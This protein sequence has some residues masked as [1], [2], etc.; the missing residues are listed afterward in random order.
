MKQAIAVI[1][2]DCCFPG[3]S[4]PRQYWR[5]LLEGRVHN[6]VS[7]SGVDSS[8]EHERCKHG[9][10]T[11]DDADL[12]NPE[13][14]GISSNEAALMDPQQ[15]LILMSAWRA[16]EDS[17]HSPR[18]M[19]GTRTGVYVGLMS[20]EWT[21]W[22]TCHPEFVSTLSGS[23]SGFCMVANRVSYCLNFTGP[24]LAIDTACSSSLTA[25]HYAYRDLQAGECDYALVGGVNLLLGEGLGAFYHAAGL[26]SAKGMCRPFSSEA[27]GISRSEGVATVFLRRF[28]DALA[29]NDPIYC[30]ILGSAV[31]HNGRSNG[32]TAPNR[33]AQVRVM[34]DAYKMAGIDPGDVAFLEAHG[35]GTRL[36]DLIELNALSD[37]HNEKTRSHSLP[38]SS[39]KGN[40]GHAEGAAGIAGFIKAALTVS[41][42]VLPP[43]PCAEDEIFS[44]GATKSFLEIPKYPK[45]FS[46][47]K[48]IGSVSSFGL[49]GSN[50]H[51]VVAGYN[52]FG[53]KS[54]RPIPRTEIYVISAP[55]EAG[56]RETIAKE[57]SLL[58]RSSS[59]T[60]DLGWTSQCTDAGWQ[61]RC[62][63]AGKTNREIAGK[64]TDRANDPGSIKVGNLQSSNI[65]FMLPGQGDEYE[66][67]AAQLCDEWPIFAEHH[68]M[69]LQALDKASQGMELTDPDSTWP[70]QSSLFALEY[71][72]GSSLMDAGIIPALF[73]GHSLGE[74]AAAV[75]AKVIDLDIAAPI[76][77]KRSVCMDR[78]PA[79][80]AMLAVHA[81]YDA[82]SVYLE[83]IQ[84]VSFAAYNALSQVV[85]S[86]D[87]EAVCDIENRLKTAGIRSTLLRTHRA[88]HSLHMTQAASDLLESL[89]EIDTKEEQVSSDFSSILLS[90]VNGMAVTGKL[91][92]SHWSDQLVK[93]VVFNDVVKLASD[94]SI[95]HFLEIGPRST[96][97]T[98]VKKIDPSATTVNFSE[99]G[100]I[101]MDSLQSG[102]ARLYEMGVMPNWEL[103]ARGRRAVR[104]HGTRSDFLPLQHY[105]LQRFVT[106]AEAL[107]D[108][109]RGNQCQG[110]VGQQEKAETFF[111]N[112]MPVITDE[113]KDFETESVAID[114]AEY[115]AA[116]V[117]EILVSCLKSSS[118]IPMENIGSNVLISEELGLDSVALM[119]LKEL[120][121]ERIPEL[122]DIVF[123]ELLPHLTTV[124]ECANYLAERLRK[125][126]ESLS[127]R[128]VADV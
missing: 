31:N 82:V 81:S 14:F 51:I 9:E 106:H 10:A 37:V 27:D 20:S 75:L 114:K 101:S 87:R 100:K 109:N 53:I 128:G 32:I 48:V 79:D 12:F 35:T 49:G 17:S 102:I 99:Q 76:V 121:A 26:S 91:P 19:S 70:T 116:E 8:K 22:H 63:V 73:F 65:A 59:G 57:A 122:G 30:R 38:I 85:L 44:L 64:L 125:N 96:L 86:G 23:G 28:D 92:L 95:T 39:V 84:G 58:A 3:V 93:P 62:A 83:D 105:P 118:P 67:M 21:A 11:L 74:I 127:L 18:R 110:E 46:E 120:L 7:R 124:G 34:E 25:L 80:G 117:S 126:N 1:G 60:S 77:A 13:Y 55:S 40:F 50:V 123:V 45:K 24:S 66:G 61:Y 98:L 90:T 36:G 29:E 54:S 43:V 68:R 111:A 113:R 108:T 94:M 72:L 16:I 6:F 15:R 97:S 41:N 4:G 112:S 103:F 56:L 52:D 89:S 33:W 88:F 42:R 2:I 107:V 78:A 104:L 119:Y 115:S 69:A 47:D 71:A 5:M